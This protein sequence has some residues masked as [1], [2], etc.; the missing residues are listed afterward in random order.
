MGAYKY[1]WKP[2]G[3]YENEPVMK[4][5]KEDTTCL[6]DEAGKCSVKDF[7]HAPMKGKKYESPAPEPVI[8]DGEREKR[9]LLD[10]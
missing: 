1:G 10:G 6:P 3:H 5:R 8:K 9:C 2:F 7:F 4:A